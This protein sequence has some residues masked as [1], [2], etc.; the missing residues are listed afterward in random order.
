M[1]ATRMLLMVV[2]A[3]A[4]VRAS[5]RDLLIERADGVQV[6]FTVE[7]AATPAARTR[8]LMGRR[9]L[10]PRHGMWFDFGAPAKVHMWM[11]D[12][13]LALDM[14]F[15]DARGHIVHIA[16]DT[17]PLSLTRV[18]APEAVRYVLEVAAGSLAQAQVTAG[19]RVIMTSH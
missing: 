5:A 13:P 1:S 2:L 4:A 17:V 11:K 7:V 18:A 8:G 19:A 10:P 3:A 16:A 9:T 14:A 12:T 6:Y 15:V